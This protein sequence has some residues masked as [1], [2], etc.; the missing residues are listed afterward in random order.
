MPT[1]AVRCCRSRTAPQPSASTSATSAR[2]IFMTAR[3]SPRVQAARRAIQVKRPLA[4][5]TLEAD[6]RRNETPSLPRCQARPFIIPISYG[7]KPAPARHP[8]SQHRRTDRPRITRRS[9]RRSR[10]S[11]RA[12]A[13]SDRPRASVAASDRATSTSRSHSARSSPWRTA[14]RDGAPR[15]ARSVLSR[16]VQRA[17][18]GI[19]R[20]QHRAA[21]RRAD[22]RRSARPQRQKSLVIAHLHSVATAHFR[23]QGLDASR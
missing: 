16:T 17:R 8:V 13:D 23:A 19:R 14:S 3:G 4:K 9:P 1:H 6:R 21:G 15:A 5:K 22:V 2:S 11:S 18:H 12:G 10:A 7:S 20:L